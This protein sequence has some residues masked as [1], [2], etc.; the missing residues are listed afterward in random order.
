MN[1][2]YR[3]CFNTLRVLLGL[4]WVFFVLAAFLDPRKESQRTEIALAL[5]LFALGALLAVGAMER[6]IAAPYEME[7]RRYLLRVLAL[8]ARRGIS[9]GHAL[10]ALADDLSGPPRRAVFTILG[11]LDE[12]LPLSEG[13]ARAG[14]RYASPHVV[15]AVRVAERTGG[16]PE[17]LEACLEE[18][19][20]ERSRRLQIGL[21]ALYPIALFWIFLFIG[22]AVMP[23]YGAIFS[24]VTDESGSPLSLPMATRVAVE[25]AFVLGEIVLPA[26]LLSTLFLLPF[27][28]PAVRRRFRWALDPLALRVPVF[29]PW[30]LLRAGERVC[31][32]LAYA[33]RAG[34]P[35]E[36]ALLQAGAASHHTLVL[37]SAERAADAVR[38]GAP[39]DR[40]LLELRLPLFVRTRAAAAAAAGNAEGL[41][42]ALEALAAEC[43]WRRHRLADDFA[44]SLYPITSLVG[45]A[46]VALFAF[47]VFSAITGL[48]GALIP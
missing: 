5:S 6:F 7:F 3:I 4:G 13:L 23:Q 35:L 26:G 10:L 25:L 43:Q 24:Q 27:A 9:T 20:G 1:A 32:P 34:L 42:R 18:S 47:G 19:L 15:E 38:A 17:T 28:F 44:K 21:A 14:V 39:A 45:G 8:G 29:G 22:S 30:L 12:G 2:R 40:A 37:H 41:A 33:V 11:A 31:R 48:Q 16:L 36:E 46:L